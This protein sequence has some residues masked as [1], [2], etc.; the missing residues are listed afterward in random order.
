MFMTLNQ[1]QRD[2]DKRFL[3]DSLKKF[4]PSPFGNI[5]QDDFI[6]EL[7]QIFETFR[8]IPELGIELS[9]LISKLKDSHTRISLDQKILGKF[10]FP[11]RFKSFT[12]GIFVV[13]IN[14]QNEK[15]LGLK[16]IAINNQPIEQIKKSLSTLIATENRTSIDY[17]FPSL[18]IEP[19]ILK[20]FNLITTQ[21]VEY[22]L[23]DPKG[24]RYIFNI[25][26]KDVETKLT[27]VED[28]IG[29]LEES[30]QEKSS[31]WSKYYQEEDLFY[32][33]YNSCHE[34]TSSPINK[35]VKNIQQKNP[36]KIVLD[37][38]NNKGGDSA[39]LKPVINY[40]KKT[41]QAK[42]K[43][44][45]LTSADTFSSAIIN[46]VELSKINNSFIIGDIPHG[47]PTH[48]GEIKNLEL[49]NS[50]LPFQLS[51]KLFKFTGYELGEVLNVDKLLHLRFKEYYSGQDKCMEYIK[52]LP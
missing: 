51:T 7:N 20:Y 18:V 36:S 2:K 26:P 1:N 9:Q 15:F 10:C 21:E 11:I 5:S 14:V 28:K 46:V 19:V 12:N 34:D 40:L 50:K 4:H 13:K 49:P 45:I 22:T 35:I 3:F 17:Y 25:T 39:V 30:L 24:L 52:T 41:I 38:R 31:S 8:N 29:S 44:F 16:L 48:F 43:I 27:D 6:H 32:L 42:R 37:F 23:E 47:S 33:Q